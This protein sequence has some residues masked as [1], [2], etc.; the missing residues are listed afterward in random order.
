[1]GD[2]LVPALPPA[3]CSSHDAAR[4]PPLPARRRSPRA[5]AGTHATQTRPASHALLL[6]PRD[7]AR[8]RRCRPRHSPCAAASSRVSVEKPGKEGQRSW[9][10]RAS[11]RSRVVFTTQARA[12]WPL[13]KKKGPA[14]CTKT[15]QTVDGH[16]GSGLEGINFVNRWLIRNLNFYLGITIFYNGYQGICPYIFG[17]SVRANF[18][19]SSIKI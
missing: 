2:S 14:T 1:V 5:A 18:S 12:R 17:L 6:S 16:H 10:S 7:A 13:S 11:N 8:A 15:T 19:L 4:A 3:P 9:E